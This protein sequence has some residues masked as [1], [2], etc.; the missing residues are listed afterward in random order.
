M[1][2]YRGTNQMHRACGLRMLPAKGGNDPLP[3]PL[4]LRLRWSFPPS[5]CQEGNWARIETD[6]HWISNGSKTHHDLRL[7]R[8][9]HEVH[10]MQFDIRA[11][12]TVTTRHELASHRGCN[13]IARS[14]LLFLARLFLVLTAT[15][16][17]LDDGKAISASHRCVGQRFVS[18]ILP[19]DPA[20]PRLS[21][22]RQLSLD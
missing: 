11:T 1:T 16:W 17:R 21:Q 10:P 15:A 19:G 8:T 18:T 12:N 13:R 5:E 4:R 14:A 22:P 6:L 7:Q 3:L 9:I 20:F 2:N